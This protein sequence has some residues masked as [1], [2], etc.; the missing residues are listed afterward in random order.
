MKHLPQ[1]LLVF[2]TLTMTS[3][4][5]DSG[6]KPGKWHTANVTKVMAFRLNWDKKISFPGII[7]QDGELNSTRIPQ[8]GVQLTNAQITALEAAVTG[9]DPGRPVVD[10]FYPHHAFVWYGASGEILGHI[11]VCFLCSHIAGAPPGPAGTGDMD[12]LKELVSELGIPLT[13]T[14]WK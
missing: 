8:D 7:D 14:D 11:D 9:G 12:A 13:N 3:C 2:T 10:C 5:T 6:L 1:I 4:S